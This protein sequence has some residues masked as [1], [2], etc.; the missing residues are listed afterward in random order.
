MMVLVL[1][2][3]VVI[4]I[5]GGRHYN[6]SQNDNSNQVLYENHDIGIPYAERL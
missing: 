6:K 4:A 5:L 1:A 3:V 2:V